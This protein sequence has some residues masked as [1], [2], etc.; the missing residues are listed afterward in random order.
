VEKHDRAGQATDGIII[1][2]MRIAFCITRATNTHS[3]LSSFFVQIMH[4][5]Y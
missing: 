2:H 1:G 3:E 5:N 4:T